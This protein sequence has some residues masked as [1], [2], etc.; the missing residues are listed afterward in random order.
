MPNVPQD[1]FQHVATAL[2]EDIGSGDITAELVPAHQHVRGG[3]SHPKP[4]Q[5]ATGSRPT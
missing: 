1:L 2:A 3:L 5:S 4:P